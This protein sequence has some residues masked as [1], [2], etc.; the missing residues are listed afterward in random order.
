MK[1]AYFSFKLSRTDD[2]PRSKSTCSTQ[3]AVATHHFPLKGTR[4]SW[5]PET[6]KWARNRCYQKT[7]KLS[8]ITGHLKVDRSQLKW[9]ATGQRQDKLSIK[10]NQKNKIKKTTIGWNSLNI[11]KS[12]SSWWWKLKRQKPHGYLSRLLG[13]QLITVVWK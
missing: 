4:A 10:K 5:W 9:A 6:D 13:H 1:S 3:T 12:V 2:R 7:R 11:F 8:K